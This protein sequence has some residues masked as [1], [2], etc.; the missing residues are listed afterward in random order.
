MLK[1]KEI[2]NDSDD[3]EK[4]E[5]ERVYTRAEL[6]RLYKQDVYEICLKRGMQSITYDSTK[7]QFIQKI[8]KQQERQDLHL[9]KIEQL[10]KG[11]LTKN[12]STTNNNNNNNNKNDDEYYN[13]YA[14]PWFIIKNI[15]TLAYKSTGSNICTCV[16]SDRLGELVC[17]RDKFSVKKDR[18]LF[19]DMQMQPLIQEH[20]LKREDMCPTHQY[21][22]DMEYKPSIRFGY[23]H[24]HFINDDSKRWKRSLSLV[25]K[26]VFG[27]VSTTLLTKVTM[28]PTKEMWNHIKN[29]YCIIKRPT[30]L[31]LQ[32]YYEDHHKHRFF[33]SSEMEEDKEVFFKSDHPNKIIPMDLF[34]DVKKIYVKTSYLL[35]TADNVVKLSYTIPNLTNIVH[36]RGI[37]DVPTFRALLTCFRGLTSLSLGHTSD[38][39][40]SE[41][42]FTMLRPGTSV[43]KLILPNHFNWNRLDARVK[44]N[45]RVVSLV[46]NKETGVLPELKQEDFPKLQ[47]TYLTTTYNQEINQASHTREC[48]E[49]YYFFIYL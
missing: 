24:D 11:I 49:V 2:E 25:S 17:K 19:V 36:E 32:D 9:K 13:G 27:L 43:T 48:L 21:Y 6:D 42:C 35:K 8:L 45:L 34:K 30:T 40:H 22:Y 28:R 47:H 5:R 46:S 16:Y 12:N 20:S 44:Q 29:K 3:D 15:L 4:E 14:L 39:D 31:T 26:R 33:L 18:R 7:E 38:I 37:V 23:N 41:I 10:K 1:R